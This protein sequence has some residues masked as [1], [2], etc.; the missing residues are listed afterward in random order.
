MGLGYWALSYLPNLSTSASILGSRGGVHNRGPGVIGGVWSDWTRCLRR[1]GIV[2]SVQS[3]RNSLD[4]L[5][6]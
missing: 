2:R 1:S 5:V 4:W 3:I 6:A